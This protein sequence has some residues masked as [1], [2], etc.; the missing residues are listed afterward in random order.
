VR[1]DNRHRV[2][3]GRISQK[4]G[5]TRLETLRQSYPG[6]ASGVRSDTKLETL[7]NHTGKS[8]SQIVR[9]ARGDKK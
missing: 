8:L 7:R 2:A 4:R 3:D 6:L 5:D 1:L 9:R